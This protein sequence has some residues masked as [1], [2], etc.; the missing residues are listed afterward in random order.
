MCRVSFRNI[1]DNSDDY[2]DMEDEDF[3]DFDPD[4]VNLDLD[5]V[6]V[7]VH[8]DLAM[9]FRFHATFNETETNGVIL[10]E[11][12]LEE[13]FPN[14]YS[15]QFDYLTTLLQNDTHPSFCN[16]SSYFLPEFGFHKACIIPLRVPFHFQIHV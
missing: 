5:D 9:N 3:L 7:A 16:Y 4:E 8:Y 12:P 15:Q 10:E 1:E 14:V 6:E 11:H 2:Y 13:E